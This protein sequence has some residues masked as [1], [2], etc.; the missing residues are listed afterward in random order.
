MKKA[1]ASFA[2]LTLLALVVVRASAVP[3][4]EPGRP[5]FALLLNNLD[6]GDRADVVEFDTATGWDFGDRGGYVCAWVEHFTNGQLDFRLVFARTTVGSYMGINDDKGAESSN[7]CVN[8]VTGQR[9]SKRPQPPDASDHFPHMIHPGDGIGFYRGGQQIDFLSLATTPCD[10]Y[11]YVPGA[12]AGSVEL[13]W[14]ADGPT[15]S[16][17]EG[18]N[19]LDCGGGPNVAEPVIRVATTNLA[20]GVSVCTVSAHEQLCSGEVPSPTV[21]TMPPT[22]TTPQTTT[23]PAPPPTVTETLTQTITATVTETVTETVAP[24]Q[25][26]G[27]QTVTLDDGRTATVIVCA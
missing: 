23:S 9:E 17:V 4:P 27:M 7:D 3:G 5:D 15:E 10:R 6:N 11:Y 1:L 12:T 13:W 22:T 25:S 8:P 20:P 21:T 18:T 14:D 24:P 19:D 26:C 2:A 16:D